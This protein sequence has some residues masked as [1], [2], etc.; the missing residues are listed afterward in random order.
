MADNERLTTKK[1]LHEMF[2]AWSWSIIH[3]A[4]KN[5]PIG[6]FIMTG[7]TSAWE[8]F[9]S[10]SWPIWGI[11]SVAIFAFAMWGLNQFDVARE[12][13]QKRNALDSAASVAPIIA[14]VA[15]VD[16]A[17]ELK[18]AGVQFSSVQFSSHQSFLFLSDMTDLF[19]RALR[20]LI[21]RRKLNSHRVCGLRLLQ[22]HG[23]LTSSLNRIR[24]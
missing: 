21:W 12:R 6:T 2:F 7:L 17:E 1:W 3:D 15:Q 18:K 8:L 11:G 24:N 22:G 13:R 9:T 23:S 20:V 19:Q 14:P 4:W 10:V 5:H 16:L